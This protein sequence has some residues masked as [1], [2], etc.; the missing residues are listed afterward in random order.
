MTKQIDGEQII[1]E[2]KQEVKTQKKEENKMK[3]SIILTVVI[4]LSAVFT[5]G[6]MFLLGMNYQKS[7]NDQVKSEAATIVKDVSVKASPSK[8]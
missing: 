8:Q 7:I 6:G 1:K 5:L 3:K 2:A 4:T